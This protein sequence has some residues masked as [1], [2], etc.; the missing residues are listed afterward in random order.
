[1]CN[2]CW[3]GEAKDIFNTISRFEKYA[4]TKYKL[5]TLISII[6]HLSVETWDLKF[7]TLNFKIVFQ[8]KLHKLQKTFAYFCCASSWNQSQ[9]PKIMIR[10]CTVPEICCATDG[11]MDRWMDRRM[12]GW[13]EIMTYRGGCPT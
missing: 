8:N 2:T 12:D 9:L 4:E 6:C 13:T 1:M 7:Q 10:R 3:P 5:I 11:Q